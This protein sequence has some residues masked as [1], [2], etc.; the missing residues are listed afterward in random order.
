MSVGSLE[1]YLADATARVLRLGAAALIGGRSP[2][3]KYISNAERISSA[4]AYSSRRDGTVG[5]LAKGQDKFIERALIQ[6]TSQIMYGFLRSYNRYLLYYEQKLRDEH[7][8]ANSDSSLANPSGKYSQLIKDQMPV[9]KE[10]KYTD[11][12]VGRVVQDYLEL[13]VPESGQY[14]DQKTGQLEDISKYGALAFVDLGPQVQISSKNNIVLTTVQGRDFTRKELISGGDYEITINGMITSK[15]PDIY[16]DVEVSKF[17]KLMQFRGV[18]TCDN[19]IL[20]QFGITNLIVL[21]FSLGT[22]QCRNIQPYTLSCVAVEPPE[23]VTV[24]TGIEERVDVAVKH[25]NKWLKWI[26]LGAQTVDPSSLLKL[27]PWV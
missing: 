22:T 4:G 18:L 11:T 19:T 8:K 15:Y 24:K 9:R 12:I 20:R 23:P 1:K 2:D 3:A 27:S 21:N 10:K 16:P 13:G 26:R 14:Y 17:L 7:I 6:T 25:T 5:Y